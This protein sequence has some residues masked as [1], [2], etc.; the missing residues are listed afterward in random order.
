MKK[1]ITAVLCAFALLTITPGCAL[2]SKTSTQEQKASDVQLL[3]YT[4]ASIGTAIAI[5]EN[6]ELKPKFE[7]A[8]TTLNTLV[9]TKVITGLLLRDII[10]TLPVKE[11]KS[12][13]ARIAIDGAT[14]LYTAS[15]GNQLNIE[16]QPM[17]MAAATGI[18]DGMKAALGK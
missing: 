6:P 2:F 17:V 4:A 3:S 12:P 7:T 13:N 9:E 16:N 1:T 15:V 11:L 10:S 8:Y 18:R 14:Y 5:Q